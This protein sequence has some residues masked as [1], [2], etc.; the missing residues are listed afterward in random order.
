MNKTVTV[1]IGGMVFHIE[2]L[3]YEKLKKYLEAIRGYFTTSDGRDEIIQDIESRIAEMFA[4]R[5]GKSRQVITEADVDFVVNALGR[6]EQVA[7]ADDDGN[8]KSSSN[9]GNYNGGNFN[10]TVNDKGYRRLYRDP[11]DKVVGG[12]CSGISH[13]VGIDPIWLRLIFAVAFFVFGSGFVLYLILLVI[14]PK[15]KTTSEKLE[16]KGQAVNID[17]IKKTIEEEVEDIKSRLN[18][19]GPAFKRGTSGIARFFE[20]VGSVLVEIL[21]FFIKFVGGVLAFVLIVIL[22]ALFVTLLG[23]T[24]VIGDAQIPVFLS[25]VFLDSTQLTLAT[26][27][28][29][30]VIGVPVLM[31][32]YRIIRS[33]FKIKS[34]SNVVRYTAS[35]IWA[36]GV[37]I[38]FFVGMKISRDFRVREEYRA[39]M[40]ISQPSGDTLMLE[41]IPNEDYNVSWYDDVTINQDIWTVGA[42]ADSI[43][44]NMVELDIVKAEGDRFELQ[45]IA[46]GRGSSR[47]EAED[48]LR[49]IDYRYAQEGNTLKVSDHYTLS[50][51]VKF[52]GQ[53]IKML[54]K[55]PVGKSVYLGNDMGDVIYDI[56]NKTNTYDLDMIGHT[57]TM[58][59]TGLEC[60]NCNLPDENKDYSDNPDDKAD[61]NVHVRIDGKNVDIKNDNDTINWDNKDV[62]IHINKEGVVIDAKEKK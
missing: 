18:G 9:N 59:E 16:M 23:I 50:K 15:A 17:N 46:R 20:G 32:L 2:E 36:A 40:P 11:D 27:G 43:N 53:K 6:P 8:A 10:S 25:S 4:E 33:L 54:L 55:V 35:I 57:W 26:I 47:R 60:L 42:G 29:G 13:Y 48:N 28:I 5:I 56:K 38:C 58:T 14:V 39:E 24:G 31:L 41:K 37:V 61:K 12:V 34:E 19:N 51:G 3:A 49:R 1:N 45:E 52:R 7:G 22:F 21:R 30:I 62:K 44:F